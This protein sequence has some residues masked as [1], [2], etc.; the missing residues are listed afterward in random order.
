M[1]EGLRLLS[2]PA[3]VPAGTIIR[4]ADAGARTGFAAAGVRHHV[5]HCKRQRILAGLC[6]LFR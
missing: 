6:A 4:P 2:G 3:A 5:T 1:D